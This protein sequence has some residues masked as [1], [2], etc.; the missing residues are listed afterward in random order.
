MK[1]H[2]LGAWVHIF[3]RHYT[4]EANKGKIRGFTCLN[5]IPKLGN[6]EDGIEVKAQPIFLF[7]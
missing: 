7:F 5:V 1:S 3:E 4:N 6:L 2:E